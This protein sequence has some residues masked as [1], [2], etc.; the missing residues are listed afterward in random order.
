MI[1]ISKLIY[2]SVGSVID[3]NAPIIRKKKKKKNNKYHSCKF[4]W[5]KTISLSKAPHC[6]EGGRFHER[7][8]GLGGQYHEWQFTAPFLYILR[9]RRALHRCVFNNYVLPLLDFFHLQINRI[10]IWL[11]HPNKRF[12]LNSF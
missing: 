10:N 9:R 2:L 12:E 5:T 7:W 3:A 4:S 11:D 6:F 8:P 1:Y